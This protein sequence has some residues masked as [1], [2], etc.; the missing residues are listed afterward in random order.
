MFSILIKITVPF[1]RPFKFEFKMILTKAIKDSAASKA[2][3]RAE[4]STGIF[5]SSFF[6]FFF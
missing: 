6:L 4:I 2:P 1:D 3:D 5:S